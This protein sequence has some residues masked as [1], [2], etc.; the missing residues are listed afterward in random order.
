M[1]LLPALAT[2][3]QHFRMHPESRPPK[4]DFLGPGGELIFLSLSLKLVFREWVAVKVQHPPTSCLE[5]QPM[6]AS[7]KAVSLKRPDYLVSSVSENRH[8]VPQHSATKLSLFAAS[9]GPVTKN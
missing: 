5:A 3:D 4:K 7:E 9:V 1:R 6:I 2:V 8:V